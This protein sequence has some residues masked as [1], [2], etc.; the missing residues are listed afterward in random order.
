M[1]STVNRRMKNNEN[2]KK[3]LLTTILKRCMVDMNLK[4][5]E[6]TVDGVI[7]APLLYKV[8]MRNSD[9]DTMGTSAVVQKEVQ[10]LNAKMI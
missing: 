8:I 1:K 4:E 6:Y 7:M 9:L 2:V 10:D 3:C 5:A